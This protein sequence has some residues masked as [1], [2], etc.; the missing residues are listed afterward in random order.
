LEEQN[1]SLWDRKEINEGLRLVE[2]AL[3]LGRV[4]MYQIQAAIAAVHAEAK[5]ADK[6]D[7]PQIVAL[8]KELM[9]INSSP[10]VALNYAAAVAMSEGFEAGLSLI[11]EAGAAG[12]LNNYYLFHAARADLLRRLNRLEEA[13]TAYTR[14]LSLTSNHVEQQYLRKRL[15]E[16]T[17]TNGHS[18]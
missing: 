10:I 6:T 14:A 18:R 7:W 8:Y 5:T 1:R 11:E 15:R 17:K 12:K 2:T 3:P 16:V 4:G 9:R 13:T